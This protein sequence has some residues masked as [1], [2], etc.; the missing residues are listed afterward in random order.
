MASRATWM[1]RRRSDN[2]FVWQKEGAAPPDVV[3]D[4]KIYGETFSAC[5][6]QIH[7]TWGPGDYEML[8]TSADGGTYKV[9]SVKSLTAPDYS[10]ENRAMVVAGSPLNLKLRDEGTDGERES[11]AIQVGARMAP[12][13]AQEEA[14][15]VLGTSGIPGGLQVMDSFQD[16]LPGMDQGGTIESHFHQDAPRANPPAETLVLKAAPDAPDYVMLLK[17]VKQRLLPMDATFQDKLRAIPTLVAEHFAK[18][19]EG[20]NLQGDGVLRGRKFTGMVE[21]PTTYALHTDAF[22][23]DDCSPKTR[24]YIRWWLNYQEIEA[25]VRS[26]TTIDTVWCHKLSLEMVADAIELYLYETGW[27]PEQEPATKVGDLYLRVAEEIQARASFLA[28]KDLEY[29]QPT[30]RHGIYGV[31]VRV[32]DKISRYTTL[33]AGSMTPKFES[34]TDSLKDLGGYSMILCAALAEELVRGEKSAVEE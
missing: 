33:K 28:D 1:L 31:I 24:L 14:R 9:G 21:D 27:T 7:I 16:K 22:L 6:P 2:K 12:S 30:R 13:D 10:T 15:Q 5:F 25:A 8:V 32:F 17:N 20:C 19:P 26:L 23:T 3:V 34:C 11:P 29:G 18:N 4:N